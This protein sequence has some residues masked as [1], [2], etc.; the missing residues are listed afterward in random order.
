[1][2]VVVRIQKAFPSRSSMSF[3]KFRACLPYCTWSTCKKSHGQ[4]TQSSA[5][6]A[7]TCVQLSGTGRNTVRTSKPLT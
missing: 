7:K 6:C 2:Q 5:G 3:W 4:G 1:M